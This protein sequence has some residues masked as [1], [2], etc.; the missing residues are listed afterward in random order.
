MHILQKTLTMWKR[1]HHQLKCSCTSLLFFFSI[2]YFLSGIVLEKAHIGWLVKSTAKA[3]V[4]TQFTQ[5]PLNWRTLQHFCH[6][7]REK[8]SC[9]MRGQF[10]LLTTILKVEFYS[11]SCIMLNFCCSVDLL[12]VHSTLITYMWQSFWL[13]NST[14]RCQSNLTR[15]SSNGNVI[16]NSFQPI[17]RL[18]YHWHWEHLT[19]KIHYQWYIALRI[20]RAT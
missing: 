16:W 13:L 7:I 14:Y 20:P 19:V 5:V 9:I 1:L 15:T 3:Q 11:P 18:N 12:M 6:W 17:Q 8:C 10:I 4:S 2:Y